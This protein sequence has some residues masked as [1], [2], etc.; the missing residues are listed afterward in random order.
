M[1]DDPR[2]HKQNG[3]TNQEDKAVF[4]K[5]LEELRNK[6]INN[7]KTEMKNTLEGINRMMEMA[8]GEHN[9]GK[10]MKG[11]RRVSETSGLLLNAPALKLQRPQN[12]KRKI[13]CLRKYSKGC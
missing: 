13:K 6:V 1:K 3:S 9:K 2:S 7:T 11:K 4:K 8:A 10:R 5:V 12:K